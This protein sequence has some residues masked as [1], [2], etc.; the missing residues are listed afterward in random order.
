MLRQSV[1]F[2][3]TVA[4]ISLAFLLVACSTLDPYTGEKKTSKATKGAFIG[5]VLGAV[6][7]LVSGG[8]AVERRQR[9][10]IGAGVGALAGGAIGHYMDRQ[11]TQLRQK[12]EGTGVSVTRNGDNITLNMPGHVTFK[13]NGSDLNADF[14]KVLDSVGLVLKEFDKTVIE[15][16]G[17]TDNTGSENYN[18]QLSEKRARTVGSFLES[19]GIR[20]MRIITAGMG[21]THPVANNDTSE[22]RRQNRRVEL[23]LVPVKSS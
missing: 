18:Q 2:R 6:A 8:D 14:F 20:K 1:H 7:G 21:E 11:E 10:L 12:L 3:F 4:A 22:G 17:H 16:A 15:V 9:A 13:T 19:R 23:T 5:G